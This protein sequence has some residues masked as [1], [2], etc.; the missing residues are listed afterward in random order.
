MVGAWSDVTARKQLGEVAVAA[1]DRLFHL[2]TS[3]RAVIYSYKAYGD[4]APTFVSENLQEVLGYAP[5]EYLDSPDFWRGS[6]HPEDLPAIEAETV[7]L[8]RKGH[9]NLQYR[10][11]RKDGRWCWVNDEQR[12]VRDGAGQ[13]QE[14]V[15]SWT[16]ITERKLA[17]EEAAQA[18]AR[19]EHLVASSPAV[20]YSFKAYDDYAP[21]F[22]SA[23]VKE[24]LGYDRAEYLESPDFWSS[25]V[26]PQDQA[27]VLQEYEQLME[28]GHLASEYRFRRK[29]GSWCWVS[30]ELRVLRDAG[31]IRSRSWAPGV[32]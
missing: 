26:H 22:I 7:Q 28:A 29:D 23:N 8:F 10:F 20:I 32:T 24:L 16:D 14:I 21:T 9:H 31:A 5:R 18:H 2:L 19:V 6:V 25:R 13:P 30:D 4:F 17:E 1:Q 12:L 15:G 11:R 3:V 27:R